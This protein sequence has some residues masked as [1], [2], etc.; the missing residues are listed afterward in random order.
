VPLILMTHE[1]T[2]ANMSK[3]LKQIAK[4]SA[5]KGEPVMIRVETFE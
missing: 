5:V 1:A 3:A 4:L 2:N